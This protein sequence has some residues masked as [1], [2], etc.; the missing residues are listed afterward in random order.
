M[1][2]WGPTDPKQM[3]ALLD[4]SSTTHEQRARVGVRLALLGDLRPGV[5]LT[6]EGVPDIEWCAIPVGEVVLAVEE[7]VRADTD[8]PSAFGV[9]PFQMAEYPIT[10]AQYQ[11]FLKASD[12]YRRHFEVEPGRQVEYGNYPAVNVASVEAM[13][14]CAWLTDR[15]GY[16][17]RLSTEWEWQQ[18][19]SS[20]HPK[21]YY[22]WGPEW[23]EGVA[24]TAGSELGRA[25]AVRLYPQ[26]PSK[27]GVFDLA[28]NVW[29]WCL[30]KYDN[31][32]DTDLGGEDSRVVRGGS[33]FDLQDDAR[34]SNR[35]NFH[36]HL[37]AGVIGFSCGV[38]APHLS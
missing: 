11:A 27:Q 16:E 32:T 12:G 6:E 36:P 33:W 2:S 9:A 5:G 3:L 18:A 28:G 37:R 25:I 23:I 15:L 26:G 7:K 24:N 29:E 13:A 17:V 22:P 38:L 4:H 34:A 20:G 31:P 1:I 35:D 10:V 14:F 21:N 30:N 8:G 19:A